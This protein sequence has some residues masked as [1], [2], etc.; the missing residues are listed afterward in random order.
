MVTV[1]VIILN[2][3]G[4]QYLKRCLDAVLRQTYES[5]EVLFVDNA[6]ADGSR[7]FVEEAYAR[8]L[9]KRLRVIA[10]DKNYGFAEGNN[11]GYRAAKA[12]KYIIL[13]NTDTVVERTWIAQLV[14]VAERF[15]EAALVG[16]GNQGKGKDWRRTGEGYTG[17]NVCMEH[18]PRRTQIMDGSVLRAFYVSGNGVLI[19]KRLCRQPFDPSY[20]AY[21]EDVYLGWLMHVRGRD[22]LLALD[23]KMD[24]LGGGTKRMSG[25]AF[26]RTLMFHGSKNQMMNMLLFYEWKNLL[27]VMPLFMLTQAG[28]IVDNPRKISA[29]AKAAAW[30]ALHIG[31]I[32]RKRFAIQRSRTVPDH[33]LIKEMS[34]KYYDEESAKRQYNARYQSIIR[35]MNTLC[36]AY[37]RVVGLQVYELSQHK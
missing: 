18:V 36:L 26:N 12:T 19:R 11:I 21:A 17:M 15:P 20:F 1:T 23:A 33:V 34:G 5:Y 9:G 6:S 24:H 2:Y 10:N 7:M 30:T 35:L 3:N 4:K 16:T 28:H 8:Q 27:R 14:R 25:Q 13:L 31:S 29:K 22:V 37:C 32:M